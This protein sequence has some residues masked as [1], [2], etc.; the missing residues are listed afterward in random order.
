MAFEMFLD[1]RFH[2]T[3]IHTSTLPCREKRCVRN[4]ICRDKESFRIARLA[5][6]KPLAREVKGG[7]EDWLR[8]CQQGFKVLPAQD[9]LTP[10]YAPTRSVAMSPALLRLFFDANLSRLQ[11]SHIDGIPEKMT[12]DPVPINPQ[13]RDE[14]ADHK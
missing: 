14:L 8:D 12:I 10:E 6:I 1:V 2:G 3:P 11:R 5:A 4:N 9:K 7:E 13:L